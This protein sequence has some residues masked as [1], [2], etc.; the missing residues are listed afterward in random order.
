VTAEPAGDAGVRERLQLALAASEMGTFL[1]YPQEDRTEPDGQMLQLFGLP[2]DGSISLSSAL[3]SLIHADDRAR[4]AD[5]VAQAGDPEGPGELREEIRVWQPDGSIR[6]LSVTARMAFSDG[7]PE[8]LAGVVADITM[9]RKAEE[10]LRTSDQNQTFLLALADDVGSESDPTQ[11]AAI[12]CERLADFLS[13]DW[14][15]YGDV[16]D[17]GE[18][19]GVLAERPPITP[20][21]RRLADVC[22]R[23]DEFRAGRP[24][25]AAVG[26]EAR[27]DT[28]S[29]A[30]PI[31][32]GGRA[33]SGLFA[34][35]SADPG[36]TA[37]EQ[38]LLMEVVRRTWDAVQRGRA[39]QAAAV[40]R[41]RRYRR[42]REI[43][44][45][46]QES[47]MAG[48]KEPPAGFRATQAYRA[49]LDDMR[50]G[51]DWTDLVVLE[52]ERLA[53]TVGDVVGKGIDAAATMGRLRSATAA[54][55]FGNQAPGASIDRLERYATK[56]SGALC[57]T[58][59]IAII[60]PHSDT[61]AYSCA[62]HPP[63]LLVD[64]RGVRYLWEARSTPLLAAEST[65]RPTAAVGITRP[66]TV[67]LYTDGLVERRGE[68][69]DVGLGRLSAVV[70]AQG[71]P[72][73][74][75]LCDAILNELL[76]DDAGQNDDVAVV[77]AR[78]EP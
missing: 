4:Y 22:P 72:P 73:V 14:V 6:W 46:L 77:I 36:W 2:P 17:T 58:L 53:L 29:A 51:G 75:S 59:A 16:D 43:S 55:L 18:W 8:R 12:A 60:D 7:R 52:D 38:A 21:R 62:G 1:W 70:A 37:A 32:R 5:A 63:P 47:L 56:V 67:V 64:D 15:A 20:A 40:E 13:V 54:I 57:A 78:L 26:G 42:E 35:R 23:P 3:A 66:C 24:V 27:R 69:V 71:N 48:P 33:A 11:I 28:V 50:V 31:L 34:H 9:R 45:R 10:A 19:V 74:D 68:P 44:I 41:A 76:D 61:V 39:E 30:V 25:F 65:P 49:G